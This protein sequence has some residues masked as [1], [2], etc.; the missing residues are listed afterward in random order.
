MKNTLAAILT[1]GLALGCSPSGSAQNAGSSVFPPPDRKVSSIV[2]PLWSSDDDRNQVDEA[3]QVARG[4]AAAPGMVI[5]DIGA[6]TGYHS[7][8]MAKVVGPKGHIYAEDI[9]PRYLDALQ[10]DVTGRGAANITVV[11]GTA[12]DPKLPVGMLDAAIMVHMYH[13]I[14]Q[15]YA[16]LYNLTPAFK[17]GGRLGIVDVDGPTDRHGTPPALLK[18]ELAAMGYRQISFTPLKNDIAYLAVFAVPAL[19]DRPAPSLIRPCKAS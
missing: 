8:Y 4:M 14:E 15:P 16:L 5:G 10:A 6:G 13:E 19:K 9:I 3:G 12:D 11:R 1:V 17:P 18:C 7:F 2:S